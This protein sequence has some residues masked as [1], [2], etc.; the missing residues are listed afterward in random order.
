MNDELEQTRGGELMIHE[1]GDVPLAVSLS[2]AE[3][4]TQ[5]ATARSFPRD[6]Q[7]VQRRLMS[8]VTLDEETAEECMYALPRGGKPIKGPSIRFAEA[9]KA[10][11]GNCR[12]ATRVVHVDRVE[13]VVIAEGIFHDLET[14]MATRAEV[15]RRITNKS[16]AI[17]S[18]DM[19][20]VTGNAAAKIAERNAVL[21]GVPKAVWRRAYEA[22]QDVIVGEVKTLSETREKAVKA[23]A[24]F[25][26]TP[27]QV[28][29]AV[30]VAGIADVTIDHIPVLRGMFAALKNGEATVEEMFPTGV[31]AREPAGLAARLGAK[32]ASGFSTTN[33]QN[34]LGHNA[35]E[36]VNGVIG[37][38]S[39]GST[40][41][42]DPQISDAEGSSPSDTSPTTPGDGA[43]PASADPSSDSSSRA[44]VHGEDDGEGRSGPADPPQSA[45]PKG[46]DADRP[47]T[48]RADAA[49]K[50][51]ESA[52][53]RG[54]SAPTTQA[55]G[56]T[57]SSALLEYSQF[58]L[59]ATTAK[60]LRV[61]DLQFRNKNAWT[62]EDEAQASLDDVLGI[63]SQRVTGELDE[64]QAGR[65][66]QKAIGA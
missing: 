54:R 60:S 36:N 51:S 9:L 50:S 61:Y 42:S 57:G 38:G 5:I 63:H 17:F 14:N 35:K 37:Q 3:I 7:S 8:L 40:D 65:A 56:E 1:A 44:P 34:E 30:G 20:I 22:V 45:R 10:S 27:E 6:L 43:D 12:V 64:A 47:P 53:P 4:D 11:Y 59:R 26:V 29:K 66:L 62:T 39:G 41:S 15:R 23:L 52:T 33:V 58:L 48:P 13:K 32:G 19:I 2:R 18:D 28:F 21:G 16:G 24:G 55:E 49:R 31:Q 46:R 25:G